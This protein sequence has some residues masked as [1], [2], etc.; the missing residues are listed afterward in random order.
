MSKTLRTTPRG[1]GGGQA[2][3]QGPRAACNNSVIHE[4]IDPGG[5]GESLVPPYTRRTVPLSQTLTLT[6]ARLEA[7]CLPIQAQVSTT[8]EFIVQ[9]R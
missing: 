6:G 5:K 3:A 9:C 4:L 2:A 8:I 7:W 1:Q